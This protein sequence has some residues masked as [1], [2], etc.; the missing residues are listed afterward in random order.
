MLAELS[1]DRALASQVLFGH[2]HPDESP[3]AHVEI[4]DLWGSANEFVAIEA[5][6]QFAK[7][8]LAEEFLTL[9]GCFGNFNYYLLL[10]ET[11]EKACQRLAAIDYECQ[12]NEKLNRL[13]GGRVLKRKSIENKLWFRSGAHIQALGWEMEL[14]SFK[15]ETHRPDGAYLDDVE[16]DE[17][18]RDKDAVD[19]SMRKLY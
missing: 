10:G 2:R 17:R 8:T 11:Y 6:R 9:G 4:M 7:T 3:P 18:V 16:N 14:Q 15:F 13:F 19:W 5:A 12:S 1:A